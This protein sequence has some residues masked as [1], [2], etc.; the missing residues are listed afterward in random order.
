MG[1]SW[2]WGKMPLI[3]DPGPNVGLHPHP[4]G[5]ALWSTLPVCGRGGQAAAGGRDGGGLGGT[6]GGTVGP[7]GE[8]VLTGLK[9]RH[10]ERR[11]GRR[12]AGR[13]LG[14]GAPARR[15]VESIASQFR[16]IS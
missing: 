6:G 16:V 7:C 13:A 11:A 14:A 15:R 1:E 9:G 4:G 12:P 10:R 2:G 5:G 8:R 3:Q